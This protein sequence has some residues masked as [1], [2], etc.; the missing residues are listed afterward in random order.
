MQKQIA[1]QWTVSI[2]ENCNQPPTYSV[3][4]QFRQAK[5]ANSDIILSSSQNFATTPAA[6]KNEAC[7]KVVK[8]DSKIIILFALM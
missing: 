1:I 3:F 5:F 2:K 7:Y 4:H 8:I 6:S